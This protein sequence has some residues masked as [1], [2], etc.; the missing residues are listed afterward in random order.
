MRA[1]SSY[2][3]LLAN[4]E[5]TLILKVETPEATVST[6]F[7]NLT[8]ERSGGLYTDSEVCVRADTVKTV[9]FWD[10]MP[11]S[12]VEGHDL[13]F[14]HEDRLSTFHLNMIT[15]YQTTWFHIPKDCN[16][17]K[18]LACCCMSHSF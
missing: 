2:I 3:V 5:G 8:M 6:H 18:I 16:I 11:C 14:S 1:L 9:I 7:K 15:F 13:N 4:H 10:G 17:I 12:A